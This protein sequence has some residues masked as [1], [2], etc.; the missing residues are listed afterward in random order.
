[1]TIRK[2]AVQGMFYPATKE[3]I[4][5]MILPY[6]REAKNSKIGAKEKNIHGIIVPH[7]GYPY[8]A[9]TAIYAYQKLSKT[10]TKIILLGPN[11]TMYVAG[12]V[13]DAHTEWETPTSIRTVHHFP[14]LPSDTR[15]HQNEH[16]LEV[17]LPLLEHVLS[18]FTITPIIIGESKKPETEQLART[19]LTH[20]D[21]NTLFV[22]STDLS[23]FHA[24]DKAESIDRQIIDDITALTVDTATDACGKNP[25][26]VA[27]E[28]CRLKKWPVHFLHHSTSADATDDTSQVVGYASFW[29]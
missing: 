11:H 6:F 22:I 3:A 2:M 18:D 8:S 19:L 7:A 26:R 10:Y 27:Q 28:I 15:P 21:E 24:L 23:H 16:A 25:L 14:E 4:E 12:A 17:Q 20:Y 29:F 9:Q 1:M 5:Q 13:Q